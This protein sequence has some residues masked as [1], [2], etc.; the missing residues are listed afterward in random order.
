MRPV[1][2]NLL[3]GISLGLAVATGFTAWVTFLRLA[4]GTVGFDKLGTTYRDVV[5]V[6]Y[7]AGLVGGLLMGL[8]W[9]I[10]RS[11][12]GSALIGVLGIFPLYYGFAIQRSPRS[13][14]LSAES[15]VTACVLSVVVGSSLGAGAWLRDHPR[16]PFWVDALRYPTAATV[17][18][19]WAF[20]LGVAV[21]AW[22]IGT[23]WAGQWPAILALIIFML[24]LVLAVGV[25]IVALRR[26]A[27]RH[28]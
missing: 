26:R 23:S 11:V 7:G 24:P 16:G 10:R 21:V 6:Y 28:L 9:P 2:R 13:E 1:S 20:A 12:V 18:W 27:T 14:W 22:L 17:R 15:L 19:L 8:V 5:R 4:A 25:S 3:T